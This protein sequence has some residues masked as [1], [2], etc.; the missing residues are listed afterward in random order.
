MTSA[1]LNSYYGWY[2][3][4]DPAGFA[5][6][7]LP[8]DGTIPLPV[9]G[10]NGLVGMTQP[11][12]AMVATGTRWGPVQVTTE[13]LT[14]QPHDL[15]AEYEEVVE[16][17]FTVLSHRLTIV[18]WDG[19]LVQEFSASPGSWRLRVHARGRQEGAAQEWD[20]FDPGDPD[21]EFVEEHLLQFFPGP[22]LGEVVIRS[23]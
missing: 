12:R 20:I 22:E 19:Q 1:I 16:V 5:T 2:D 14:E 6:E 17:D 7:T 23:R 9:G 15:A 10:A 21:T 11:W 13:V 8:A 4:I 3:I 18:D